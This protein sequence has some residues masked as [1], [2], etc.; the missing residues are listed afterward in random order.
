MARRRIFQAT[1]VV[2][3]DHR[4]CKVTLQRIFDYDDAKRPENCGGNARLQCR[5]HFATHLQRSDGAANCRSCY[6][7]G[8]RQPRRHSGDRTQARSRPS[9]SPSG[10]SRLRRKPKDLLPPRTGRGRRYYHHDSSRLP[11]HAAVDPSD[12]RFGVE[13]II[14]L[15]ACVTYSWRRRAAWRH[16]LVEIRLKSI[17]D[18]CRKFFARCK[19][20]GVSHWLSRFFA[21]SVGAFAASSELR[22][23]CFRQPGCCANNRSWLCDRRGDMSCSLHARSFIDKF[24]QERT[25]RTRLSGN[26]RAFPPGALGI[27]SADGVTNSCDYCPAGVDHLRTATGSFLIS[28]RS[29]IVRWL[30][31]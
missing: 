22:R 28:P 6:C 18:S 15:C 29:E 3:N 21:P 5:A 4:S 17:P 10:K 13:R 27:D 24:P 12:G 8:R 31:G 2:K 25:L 11:V 14:P 9:R 20:I 23:F 7:R 1:C 30:R 26:G 16:A 19:A